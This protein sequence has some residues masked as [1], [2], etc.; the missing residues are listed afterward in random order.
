MVDEYT[1]RDVPAPCCGA[2]VR[3]KVRMP[4]HHPQAFS[5]KNVIHCPACGDV[6]KTTVYLMTETEK[7]IPSAPK[8]EL[9]HNS[10]PTGPP[11]D[12]ATNLINL[13]SKKMFHG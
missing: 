2:T 1:E 4:I 12:A 9:V 6:F 8:L 7:M 10:E 11:P 13:L 3:I 5:T